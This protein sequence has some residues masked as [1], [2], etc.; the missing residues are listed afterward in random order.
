MDQNF[1][2]YL[3]L[4]LIV[5]KS[6]EKIFGYI[7]LNPVISHVVAGLILG[8]YVLGFV[9]P[10]SS[11]EALSYLGLML[12]MFYTGLTT[13]FNELKKVSLWVIL[14]GFSGVLITLTLCYL[15]LNFMK[16]DAVK[17]IILS[18][19]L[20]NT[21]TEVAA[22]TVSSS[23][24]E[25]LKSIVI[26]A[27]VVDDIVAVIILSIVSSSY[28]GIGDVY[29]TIY[30]ATISIAFLLS[31][32]TLS[33]FLVDKPELFYQ[34]LALNRTSFASI[35]I[36]LASILAFIS[37]IIGLNELIGLYLAGLLIS[38]GRESHDPLLI[39]NTALAEFID[40]LKIFIESL[41]LP[42]FFTYIGLIAIP[43]NINPTLY[44]TLLIVAIVG[45]IIGCG[46]PS[47]I[48]TKNKFSSIAIGIA[49]VGRGALE[50][51]LLKILLD[52]DIISIVDYTTI[53][54]IALTTTILTP[55]IFSL[56]IKPKQ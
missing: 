44:T 9:Q 10:L 50:T 51:V 54:F 43:I 16:F 35:S 24:N 26:G 45:K 31:I 27:S 56:V 12:L 49:V 52:L 20:S 17:S 37:K 30:V 2:L 13:S 53:L 22:A 39:T 55:L 18:I 40:Q 15:T 28:I 8:P 48:F 38:R 21:A 41:A 32:I 25:L 36:L 34:K 11:L 1:L 7:H 33:K 19:I 23:S 3:I 14:I 29:S 6:L 5:A 4:L 46:I 42:L 47:Y